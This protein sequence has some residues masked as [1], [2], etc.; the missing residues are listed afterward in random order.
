MLYFFFLNFSNFN[1]FGNLPNL[2]RLR[3]SSNKFTS[4]KGFSNIKNCRAVNNI[5]LDNNQIT[6]LCGLEPL[7]EFPNLKRV[8]LS[9]N[10]I[11]ELNVWATVP[12]LESLTI[13]QNQIERIISI[14][15]LPNLKRLSLSDNKIR[16]LGKFENLPKLEIIFVDNNPI[17]SFSDLEKLP[18]LI[19]IDHVNWDAM[20]EFD[21]EDAIEY[22]EDILLQPDLDET[23]SIY[24][25]FPKERFWVNRFMEVRFINDRT[26][27]YIDDV[28][29]MQCKR[30]VLNIPIEGVDI[31]DDIKSID[32]A[33]EL[34]SDSVREK[35]AYT[36]EIPPETEFWAHCS[37]LQAWYKNNYDTRLIH[38][39]LAFHL[40]KELTHAGDP[41]AKHVFKEEIAKRYASGIPTVREYLKMEGFLSH[42]SDEELA[43]L[44]EK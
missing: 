23:N 8:D 32:E 2:E 30:L 3:L 17:T 35:S 19:K 44:S 29:F 36:K 41:I 7:S 9:H 6:N 4:L 43:S 11:S 38:H 28:E 1:W 20:D 39:S 13:Y 40:L 10:S 12:K 26:E 18:S 34:L 24:G 27:I 14:K 37:N 31:L 21:L 42:L 22:L 16:H 33:T 25:P 5:Y 15:N